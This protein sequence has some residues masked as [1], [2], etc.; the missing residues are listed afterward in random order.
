[1]SWGDADC[2][3]DCSSVRTLLKDIRQVQAPRATAGI[4]ILTGLLLRDGKLGY[5]LFTYMHIIELL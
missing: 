1:M 4:T 5:L 3:G 2:G